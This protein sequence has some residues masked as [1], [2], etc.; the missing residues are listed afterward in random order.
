M[1]GV[2]SIVGED[3]FDMSYTKKWYEFAPVGFDT[4][5]FEVRGGD[6]AIIEEDGH[7]VGDLDGILNAEVPEF[8]GAVVFGE[9]VSGDVAEVFPVGFS[10]AVFI[11]AVTRS[12]CCEGEV[13]IEELGNFAADKF[14]VAVCEHLFREETYF[15]DELFDLT[16][17]GG[18]FKVGKRENKFVT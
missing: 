5:G 18:V 16:K 17:N 10:K 11:L 1:E 3:S 12:S 9:V 6:R 8:H 2:V 15:S 7:V 14:E 4:V 13:V